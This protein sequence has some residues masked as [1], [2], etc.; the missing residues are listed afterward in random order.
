MNKVRGTL[1][2]QFVLSSLWN[3]DISWVC[4]GFLWCEEV[5]SPA[6]VFQRLASSVDGQGGR[7]P[8]LQSLPEMSFVFV[9]GLRAAAIL[10][11]AIAAWASALED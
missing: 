11:I 2:T 7:N 5:V 9:R 4:A 10:S 8:W 3:H 1:K 6:K